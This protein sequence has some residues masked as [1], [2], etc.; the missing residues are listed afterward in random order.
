MPNDLKLWIRNYYCK[1]RQKLSILM[2]IQKLEFGRP[3]TEEADSQNPSPKDELHRQDVVRKNKLYQQRKSYD[4]LTAQLEFMNW[5]LTR[6]KF[7]LQELTRLHFKAETI[8][9]NMRKFLLNVLKKSFTTNQ[10]LIC[11]RVIVCKE[12]KETVTKSKINVL[13]E[14]FGLL[15]MSLES[16]INNV[17]E[18]GSQQALVDWISSSCSGDELQDGFTDTAYQA[19]PLSGNAQTLPQ[20]QI[21]VELAVYVILIP[22]L[23]NL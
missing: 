6:A 10:Q 17:V 12:D 8:A 18:D 14:Y 5:L 21:L 19:S 1:Q 16:L 13:I 2:Q 23:F 15:N 20:M 22:N 7:S 9:L 4:Q 11:Q 3:R